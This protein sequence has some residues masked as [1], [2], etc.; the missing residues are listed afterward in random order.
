M[1]D[2]AGFIGSH[3]AGALLAAGRDVRIL[4]NLSTG[5]RENLPDAE[6]IEGDLRDR[7]AVRRA[8]R[9]VEAVY[10]IA[11]LPSVPR[12]LKEPGTTN[13]VNVGGTFQVL[14]EARAAGVRRVVYAGSS[15]VYGNTPELPKREDH[16]LSPLSP[17]AASKLGGEI[18]CGAFARSTGLETVVLRFF[19]VYGP[20]QDPT[21]AYAA[22]IPI[23]L[24][25]LRAGEPL[26]VHGDGG[27]TRDFTY[28]GD[29]VRGLLAAATAEGVSGEVFNLAGGQSTSILD[30]AEVA[31]RVLGAE[32]KIRHE[33]AREGDVR[34]SR[35]DGTRA[36]KAFGFRTEVS[37][38]EGLRRTVETLKRL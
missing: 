28:V 36:R 19:N 7:E 10:H 35:G 33:P 17:Y 4:D 38:E 16:P 18:A 30:L 31:G 15:S 3:L 11:A 12:S 29:I 37:L 5:R 26:P 9:D 34:D 1:T 25:K 8:V 21:S 23:F 2:G 13:D 6:F 14:E 24:T 32:V 20:R 27:Q 22:V